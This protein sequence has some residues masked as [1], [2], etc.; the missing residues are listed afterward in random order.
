[1]I[2]RT[3]I[4]ILLSGENF[5]SGTQMSSTVLRNVYTYIKGNKKRE[6]EKLY[7]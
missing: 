7:Q 3:T 2:A 4:N 5:S 6:T 1:M